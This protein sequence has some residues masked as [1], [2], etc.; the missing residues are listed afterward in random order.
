V[1]ANLNDTW[2]F[3]G[4]TW[5]QVATASAPPVRNGATTGYDRPTKKLILFGGFNGNQYLQDTWIWDGA[6]STWTQAN[7]PSP[8]PK[9][10]G[11][12]MF[13]WTGTSWTRLKPSTVP[14]P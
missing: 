2:A 6:T 8:P 11:A 3:D 7:M 5:T 9:A 4:T 14:Y 10:T 1:A 12:M 13:E